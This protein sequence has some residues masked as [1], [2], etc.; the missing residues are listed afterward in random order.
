MTVKRNLRDFV[1]GDEELTKQEILINSI[2][3]SSLG[4]PRRYFD[5]SKLQELSQSILKHGVLQPLLVRPLLENKYE[6]VAGER[7]LRAAKMAGLTKVP[8]VIRDLSDVDAWQL[9]LIE[10]LQREDLNPVDETE[11]ILQLLS[12]RLEAE[13]SEVKSLLYRMLNEAKGKI[14]RAYTDT[15]LVQEVEAIF[16]NLGLM[17]WRS[18]IRNRLPLLNLPEEIL[19]VLREGKISYTKA[20]AIA[21]VKDSEK[22]RGLLQEAIAA[23]LT[24]TEIKKRANTI[25]ACQG[26]S[27]PPQT[28]KTRFHSTYQRL[29]K[30]SAWTE[31]DKQKRLEDLLQQMEALAEE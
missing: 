29:K 28:L 10:N 30:S 17:S 6:L 23:N 12:I 20:A 16:E 13:V 3:L 19:T 15:E 26:L 8:I 25:N 31:P 18:F 2:V 1:F 24:L 7:R 14:V 21:K 9:A 27:H 11:G 22:R 5:E 4:Q